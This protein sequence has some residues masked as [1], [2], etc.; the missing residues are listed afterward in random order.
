ME[1]ETALIKDLYEDFNARK[2][3]VSFKRYMI[4]D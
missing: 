3:R 4:F 1:N 2:V